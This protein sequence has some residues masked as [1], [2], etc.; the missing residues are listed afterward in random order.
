[1]WK[2]SELWVFSALYIPAFEPNTATFS[3]SLCI[4]SNSDISQGVIGERQNLSIIVGKKYMWNKATVLN[5]IGTEDYICFCAIF[6]CY[7]QIL[8]LKWK[9]GTCPLSFV[10]TNFLRVIK[11]FLS[12]KELKLQVVFL[13]DIKYNFTCSKLIYLET[14]YNIMSTRF[15]NFLFYTLG[16]WYNPS[17]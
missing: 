13:L 11:W 15:W 7:I 16:L 10:P 9:L 3:V 5:K 12:F 2:V 17:F 8:F 4:Q 6:D 14:F 1:M